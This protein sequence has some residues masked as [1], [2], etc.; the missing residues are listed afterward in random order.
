MSRERYEYQISR[1]YLIKKLSMSSELNTD[2][3]KRR[4][5]VLNCMRVRNYDLLQGEIDIIFVVNAADSLWR[6]GRRGQSQQCRIN[7]CSAMPHG[8]SPLAAGPCYGVRNAMDSK[9]TMGTGP[10]P[11]FLPELHMP[12]T[13][14]IEQHVQFRQGFAQIRRYRWHQQVV[15]NIDTPDDVIAFNMALIPRPPSTRLEHPQPLGPDQ[16]VDAGRL[17]AMLPGSH[18]RLFAPA[19][20]LRSLNC[21]LELRKIE[22]MLCHPLLRTNKANVMEL[23]GSNTELEWLMNR[24]LGELLHPRMGTDIIIE[25]YANALCVELARRIRET[26]PKE[27]RSQTGGL[28]PWRMKILKDRVTQ[29]TPPPTLPELAALCA[30]TVRHLGRAF[31]EETGETLGHFVRQATI[32]RACRLLHETDKPIA[33]IAEELGF[34]SAASFSES[35]RRITGRRPSAFR[36]KRCKS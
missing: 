29:N 1:Q 7:Q 16:M 18:V 15:V 20:E 19:G 26:G 9:H 33:H 31:K 36:D 3:Y 22:E 13:L 12:V 25:S 27:K 4:N 10:T 34:S 17:L 23:I 5:V 35:F 6:N 8:E 2:Q 32:E 14:E 11:P 28:A 24:I 21:T 30:M